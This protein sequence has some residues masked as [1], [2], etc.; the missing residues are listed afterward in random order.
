MTVAAVV[1]GASAGGIAAT[2]ALLHELP[3][4]LPCPVLLVQHIQAHPA[5]DFAVVY[6]GSRLAVREA[7]DKMVTASGTLY[8][9]PAGYH[10]LV[11]RDGTLSLSVDEPVSY[12]RPSIDVLF[13]S[14]AE[15]YA[16][17]LVAVVLTGA[18][19]DGAAGVVA[20]KRRGGK[21]FIQDPQ[22]AE[23]RTMPE[24][25]IARV[26]PDLIGSPAVL[27]RAIA[28]LIGKGQAS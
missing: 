26:A 1:V 9:A 17:R 14:A 28:A 6:A 4:E 3:A 22:T 27:G 15:T 20:V 19:A 25:A 21:A 11:E 13:E 24:A 16:E 10:L 5:L 18:N 12:A 23:V 8:V 7:E 2:R